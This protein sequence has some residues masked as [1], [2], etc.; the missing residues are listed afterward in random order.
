MDRSKGVTETAELYGV[1]ASVIVI[2]AQRW[3]ET[4]SSSAKPSGGSISP[5]EEHAGFL[6]GL[7]TD[8]PDLTFNEIVAEMSQGRDRWQS[9]CGVAVL[10]ATWL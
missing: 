3:K 10:R 8:H 6:L 5:L 7:V 2:W 1:S 4:G 9:D